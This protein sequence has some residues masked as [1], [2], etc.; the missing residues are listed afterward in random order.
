MTICV[1][2]ANEEDAENEKCRWKKNEKTISNQMQMTFLSLWFLAKNRNEIN[3]KRKH[4]FNSEISF[5]LLVSFLV[6]PWRR[7][8]WVYRTRYSILTAATMRFFCSLHLL[9]FCCDYGIKRNREKSEW[10]FCSHSRDSQLSVCQ[11]WVF[12][13]N[14]RYANR[15]ALWKVNKK[16]APRENRSVIA[17]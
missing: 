9:L 14:A 1:C 17:S 2:P 5:H 15:F 4:Q 12:S 8:N 16:S 10:V 7:H 13:S 3:Q 11:P 6:F